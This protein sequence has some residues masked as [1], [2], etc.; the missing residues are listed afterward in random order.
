MKL[1]YLMV[2][3]SDVEPRIEGP[4]VDEEARLNFARVNRENYGDR[5]GL[6]PIDL[7]DADPIELETFS[8][9]NLDPEG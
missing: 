7:T 2:V 5:D 6:F 1:R 8:Y 3:F 4:F 9:G